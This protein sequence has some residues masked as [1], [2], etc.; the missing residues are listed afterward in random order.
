MCPQRLLR[1]SNVLVLCDTACWYKST[2][3]NMY[4]YMMPPAAPAARTAL[5]FGRAGILR[6]PANNCLAFALAIAKSECRGRASQFLENSCCR[7]TCV[8]HQTCHLDLLQS[9]TLWNEA[10]AGRA[11]W[12][13]NHRR[14]LITVLVASP[15]IAGF[16]WPFLGSEGV[17]LWRLCCVTSA[18]SVAI[19]LEHSWSWTLRLQAAFDVDLIN[20]TCLHHNTCQA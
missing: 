7:L 18:V 13:V 9:F 4:L 15:S 12:A 8:S 14:H 17:N 1:I 3:A 16:V 19:P 6:C 5:P 10:L 2:F 20:F 11:P